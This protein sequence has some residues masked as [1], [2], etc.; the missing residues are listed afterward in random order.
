MRQKKEWNTKTIEKEIKDKKERDLEALGEREKD[1][2]I[3]R[4]KRYR[5]LIEKKIETIDRVKR[6]RHL[7]EKK[8]ETIDRVKR[9][10]QLIE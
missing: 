2:S 6:Y 9:Y 1:R 4:V 7:I 10:R 3:D 8:I 5:H